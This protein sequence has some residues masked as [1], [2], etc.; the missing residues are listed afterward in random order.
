MGGRWGGE[1]ESKSAKQKERRRLVK[2]A[3]ERGKEK[4][5]KGG[6]KKRKRMSVS[7]TRNNVYV[8]E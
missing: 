3:G 5:N 2:K 1:K 8:R 7:E 6:Q 4:E